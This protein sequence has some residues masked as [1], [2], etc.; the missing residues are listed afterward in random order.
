M[1]VASARGMRPA[2]LWGA[3][4]AGAGPAAHHGADRRLASGGPFAL[5]GRAAE[6]GTVGG[7]LEGLRSYQDRVHHGVLAQSSVRRSWLNSWLKCRLRQGTHL[8]WL[9]CK[10][11]DG[12]KHGLCFSS[13]PPGQGGIQILATATVAEAVVDVPVI[14]S[15]KLQQSFVESVEVPQLP[16][17]R[18]SGGFRCFTETGLTVQT[19]QKTGCW[20]GAVLG[21]GHASRCATTGPDDRGRSGPEG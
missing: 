18:H 1:E 14:I 6:G 5:H 15:D 10:P 9:Q 17:H 16:V 7:C 21:L 2:P 20:P 19:V 4:A 11:L 12:R 3:P 8:R 13:P